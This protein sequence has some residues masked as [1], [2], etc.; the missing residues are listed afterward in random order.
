MKKILVVFLVLGFCAGAIV[1]G[2]QLFAAEEA[3]KKTEKPVA[4]AGEAAQAPWTVR[5][6]KEIKDEGTK[7]G[8]CEIFQSLIVK[9]TKQRFVEIA[10]SYPKD[11][12]KARGVIVVPLGIMLQA[13]AQIKVDNADP[14][15]FQARYCDATGCF[16]FVDLD[17]KVLDSMRKGTKLVVS[18]VA[19]NKKTINVE[20]S[21]KDFARALKEIS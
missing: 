18:F 5:C 7:R 17:E 15:K 9:E 6:N 11:K 1:A 12:T 16:G 21:L 20:M 2:P 10:I 8:R 13:G 14:F 4:A 3:A 19:M